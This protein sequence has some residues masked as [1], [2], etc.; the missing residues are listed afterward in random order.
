MKKFL[1]IILTFALML[2]VLP[3]GLFSIPTAAATSGYYTYEVSN[4]EATITA[5]RETSGYVTIPSEL[6]GYPV[7]SIGQKV[8]YDCPN[9]TGITIPDS[10]KRIDSMAFY[11]C[12]GL[13]R[14]YITDLTAWCKI[15]FYSNHAN[16]LSYAQ[17]LYL[18]GSLVTDA[19]IPDGTESI[20]DCAFYNCAS[21]TS[22]TIP[23]SVT[24]IGHFA[25]DGCTGLTNI[26]IPN[27]MTSI[28][29]G[30]FSGCIG[31]T[32]ITI[33][34]SVTSIGNSAFE[35]CSGITSINIPDS[36]TSI[37]E[38]A[39]S[40]C[41][42]LTSI[43][44]PDIVTN[45]SACVF[46]GCTGLISINIPGSVTSISE[47]AF[48]G[49]TGLTSINIPDIVTSISACVFLGCTGLTS[50]T[51]PN[52]V[53]S[54]GNSAFEDCSGITSI[55]IP[56]SVTSI[57]ERAF[58]NCSGI[59]TVNF[60][61]TNCVTMGPSWG[62]AFDGCINIKTVNI[63]DDVTIIPDYA[64]KGCTGLISI[65][66]PDSVITIGNNALK[67]C[68]SLE[69]ITLPFVGENADGTGFTNFGYIF[70]ANSESYPEYSN[71]SYV[72]S[73]LKEVIITGSNSITSNAFYECTSITD[74]TFTGN[75]KIMGEWAFG[76]CTGLKSVTIPESCVSIM[77]MAFYDCVNL[78]DVY[79]A[80]TDTQRQEININHGND[81]L[82][83]YAEW[84]YESCV[85]KIEH[86]F[87]LD[88]ICIDCGKLQYIS[89]DIDGVEGVTDRD[90]VYLLYHTF[91][92]NLYPVN[93]DCDFNGDT[94]VNDKDAIYL[95]Y[96]TF[97][98]SL[99]PLS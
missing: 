93:Q 88:K 22:V 18:N 96:H 97:L 55:T 58:Y 92:E 46:S 63:G 42:G 12:V 14:V 33:P 20:S 9:I 50:I 23:D 84:H 83:S 79:Y 37:G 21:L 76:K 54:I 98:P 77:P 39:F 86:D 11:G 41:T 34:N 35:D 70:G 81:V 36:V 57:G 95:L 64:F 32:S 51:I 15:D 30:T 13:K 44:I 91:L 94:Q 65:E 85:G 8:F 62:P 89:G 78:S 52:S 72:P 28:G 31:L 2:T 71:K 16:P 80:G 68:T 73:S 6:G 61:A 38:R 49:C 4:G 25:F 40:G 90:A 59:T 56:D 82:E 67:G 17:N 7:T 19:V 45:I 74:I 26:T 69:K 53:A 29:N 66:I 24:S 75:V 5:C 1:S 27:S 99:Y 87:G 43:N 60:N 48:S 3:F 10:V 47:Y